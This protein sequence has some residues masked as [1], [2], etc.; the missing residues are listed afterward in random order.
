MTTCIVE[1][2]VQEQKTVTE[3]VIAAQGGDRASLG[4]L[5][6]RYR[7]RILAVAMRRLGDEHEA[8]ELCQEVFLQMIKKIG[9]LREPACFSAWI[10]SI[11]RRMAVNRAVRRKPS[12]VTEPQTLEMTCVDDRT[13]PMVVEADERARHLRD[14]L[15]RLRSLD[16][17]TLVAFYLRGQSLVEMATQFDAPVGT[18]KRRLHVARQRLAKEVEHLVSV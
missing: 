8:Q 2:V 6:N 7:Q 14:G 10:Q 9:Q 16:R 5:F 4:E 11:A 3:L 18:I 1:P 13:P 17:D 15:G 12:F